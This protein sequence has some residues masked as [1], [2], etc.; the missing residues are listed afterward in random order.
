MLVIE[1]LSLLVLTYIALT[2]VSI[3]N[4]LAK[5][6]GDISSIQDYQSKEHAKEVAAKLVE[7]GYVKTGKPYKKTSSNGIII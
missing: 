2:G 1:I 6:A 7:Q 5:I 3:L 4:L